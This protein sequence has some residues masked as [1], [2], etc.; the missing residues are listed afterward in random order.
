[1]KWSGFGR[2]AIGLLSAMALGL[3]MTACGGGT[4]A[5]IWTVGTQHNQI[6]GYKVDDYTGNLT[7]VPN[8]PFATN[9]G[10][11]VY[12]L[13]KP[14]GRYLYLIN[15]G[16]SSTSTANSSDSGIAVFSVGGSGS[17]TYQTSFQ[18]QG[19]VHKWAQFD[20]TGN[21]LFVL[22]EYSP[23]GDGNGAITTFAADPNTGR[24][25]LVSQTGQT[26]SGGGT[27]PTYLEVGPS[28]IM[29]SSTGSCLFTLNK[30]AGSVGST[31][32]PFAEASGQLNTVTTGSIQQTNYINPT[33]INGNAS[34]IVVTDAGPVNTSGQFTTSGTIYP[35]T[36]SGTCG[37]TPFTGTGSLTND[38]SVSNP[39][40]SF[41]DASNKYLFI[42][43]D[44]VN[45]TNPNSPYSQISA[46]N[47]VSGN[48]TAIAGEPFTAGS[49]PTCMVEDPTSK[50]IYT[51]NRNDGT[52][53]GYTFANT[54]GSLAPLP[55][56]SNFNTGNTGLQCLAL[57]GSV[58]N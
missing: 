9:G 42:M 41:L 25:T 28:P 23:S 29:M 44:S 56:G 16:S 47:I 18:S 15:Q 50:W 11:P 40:Y 39:V 26:P 8:S 27:A 37:L 57:S 35:S 31:I 58:S 14:G 34:T 46:Y 7:A 54:Q 43:N 49:G 1:M 21:Y 33:S 45:T 48:L 19:Y 2:A 3:G 51:A 4:I 17:L 10:A 22:D 55:R 52:I 36:V 24:L 38:T 5:Y 32:T 20:G 53:T 12:L 13:V 30:G 6:I